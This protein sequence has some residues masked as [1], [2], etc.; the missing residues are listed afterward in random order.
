MPSASDSQFESVSTVALVAPAGSCPARMFAISRPAG[1][2]V[3]GSVSLAG[4]ITST[5]GAPGAARSTK[6]GARAG[7]GEARWWPSAKGH[8]RL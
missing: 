8:L 4:A 7:S 1:L 2:L 3:P 6:C 5:R